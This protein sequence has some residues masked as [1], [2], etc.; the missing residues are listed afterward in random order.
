MATEFYVVQTSGSRPTNWHG[1]GIGENEPRSLAECSEFIDWATSRE[2]DW[3]RD[4]GAPHRYRI[5]RVTEDG[6]FRSV[7][8]GSERADYNAE[9][10][11]AVD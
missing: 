10:N 4:G 2:C 5:V 7:V 1:D 8:V 6:V 3:T 9:E 11:A